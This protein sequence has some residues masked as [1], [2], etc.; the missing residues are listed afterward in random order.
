MS[1]EKIIAD[2]KAKREAK[3]TSVQIVHKGS[4]KKLDGLVIESSIR[5]LP[6][7]EL[8]FR[9]RKYYQL[10]LPRLCFAQF[11]NM[12]N[13]SFVAVATKPPTKTG[14][15]KTDD[16]R[17]L[18]LPHVYDDGLICMR[19]LGAAYNNLTSFVDDFFNSRFDESHVDGELSIENV[20]M[21]SYKRWR[22]RTEEEGLD[23][24]TR[25]RFPKLDWGHLDEFFCKEEAE[26]RSPWSRYTFDD[27][28]YWENE[29]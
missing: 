12:R 24:I 21:K 29:L 1:K 13:G 15:I 6:W 28:D 19:N 2:R 27:D 3:P 5:T 26:F 16:L 11:P 9:G 17:F 8:A 20:S 23:W 7:N 25:V 10:A 22:K 18:P 14:K 4:K